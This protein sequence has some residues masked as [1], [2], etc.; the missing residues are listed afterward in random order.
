M[1]PRF[2]TCE[3]AVSLFSDYADGCLP[4]SRVLLLRLHLPLCPACRAILA[5]MRALPALV[6]QVD[7]EAPEAARAALRGALARI[8]RGEVPPPARPW[9]ATPVPEEARDLLGGR[10]DLP[11]A[12]LAAAHEALAGARRPEAGP[13]H[14][15]KGILERLPPADQWRWAADEGGRRRAELIAEPGGSRLVLAFAPGDAPAPPHRHLGSESVLVLAGTL[16]DDGLPLA[17]GTWVHHGRGSVH[18]PAAVGGCWC[19][20]REEGETEAA[21]PPR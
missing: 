13:F 14:L 5:T 4:S 16:L 21:E 2:I 10:P 17:P 15:P 6:A 20:I 18:A 3:R 8:A 7:D 9:P 11:L 12:I 1:I 19:L